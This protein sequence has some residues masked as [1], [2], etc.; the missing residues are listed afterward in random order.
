[1]QTQ[2]SPSDEPAT[3]QDHRRIFFETAKRAVRAG[4][5]TEAEVKIIY[6]PGTRKQ[7]YWGRHLE[8]LNWLIAE[9]TAKR[10]VR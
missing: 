8:D 3:R 7:N 9:R 4:L 5:I 10:E 2:P 6:R 1:M